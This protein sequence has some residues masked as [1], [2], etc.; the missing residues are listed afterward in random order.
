MLKGAKGF[1]PGRYL[2]RQWAEN[3][4]RT[5]YLRNA[6]WEKGYGVD[7][8]ET[9]TDW[10][11]VD[12]MMTAMESALQEGLGEEGEGV[13]AFSHLSHLYSQGASV[14]TTAIFRLGDRHEAT[15]SR[16]QSMKAAVCE[17]VVAHG[18][19][20][21][22]QH[23]VGTDHATYLPAEKGKLG[24]DALKAALRVFDPE[25]IMNPGKLVR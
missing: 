3:R 19:T 14:Y 4:F 6:L 23:G 2:G 15:L 12:H 24:V 22:H 13:H 11:K 21:S 16:W 10:P 9:A 20:I 18:G 17:A 5:P 8:F 25:G 7:T 1:R